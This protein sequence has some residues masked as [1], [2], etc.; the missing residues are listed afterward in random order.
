MNGLLVSCIFLWPFE[1]ILLAVI[2][3]IYLGQL[4]YIYSK[5]NHVA[6]QT[7]SPYILLVGGTSLLIDAIIN[8]SIQFSD[9][10]KAECILGILTTVTSYYLGWACIALRA[11]RVKAV[12]DTY[13]LYLREL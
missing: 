4:Y 9:S 8:F 5:R 6:V 10:S 3:S 11:Y 1:D 2:I 12:F 7:R 13:D